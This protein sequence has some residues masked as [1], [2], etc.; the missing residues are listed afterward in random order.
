MAVEAKKRLGL[1]EVWLLINPQNPHKQKSDIAD[2]SHR[3]GLCEI[4]A[5]KHPWLKVSY[6]EANTTSAYTAETLKNI[7]KCYNDTQFVWLMGSDNMRYFHKWKDWR[8]IIENTPI[9]IFSREEKINCKN[10]TKELNSPAFNSYTKYRV[11]AKADLT[12]TPQWRILFTPV[13][14]GRATEIR[15]ILAEK[16]ASSP[17]LTSAQLESSHLKEGYRGDVYH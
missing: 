11:N 10:H 7:K 4:L 5:N 3:A 13:H 14:K 16:N 12:A 1:K 9:V 2:F 17:H 15:G 6:F 8:E